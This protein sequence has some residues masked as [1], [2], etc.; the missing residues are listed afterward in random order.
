MGI[1]LDI[2]LGLLASAAAVAIVKLIMMSIDWLSQKLGKRLKHSGQEEVVVDIEAFMNDPEFKK[3]L[4][5][6]EKMKLSE[7]KSWGKGSHFAIATHNTKTGK[8]NH[9]ERVTAQKVDRE[10]RDL[11]REHDGLLVVEK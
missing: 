10:C 2:L 5:K 8:I 6:A 11:M 3:K 1:V 9:F 7:L 4:G